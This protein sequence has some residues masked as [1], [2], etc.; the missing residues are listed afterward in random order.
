MED[1]ARSRNGS[2]TP[3]PP[4][5]S[6][7]RCCG[8]ATDKVD[9]DVEAE[10]ER[11]VPP[12]R[13]GRGRP[14]AGRPDRLAARR[15]RGSCPQ[16]PRPG[17]T[18]PP[19]DAT[20][21]RGRRAG[22][23]RARRLGAG[24]TSSARAGRLFASP[25][26][27]R[28]ARERGVDIAT[29]RGTGPER[30]RSSPTTSSRRRRARPHAAGRRQRRLAARAPAAAAA[31]RRSRRRR[32]ERPRRPD[33]AGRTSRPPPPRCCPPPTPP[34]QRPRRSSRSPGCAASSRR[35]CTPACQEMAQLTL[36]TDV[37]DGRRGRAAGPAQGAVGP[38]GIPVPTVTDLVVRAAALAL[39]EHPRLNA[40]VQDNA[41][42][43]QPDINVGLAVALDDGLIVPVV[44]DADRTAVVDDRGR[45]PA[46][47]AA[48]AGRQG[49]AARSRRRRRSPSARSAASASTSSRR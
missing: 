41:I 11:R 15:G 27:R 31:G 1:R 32:R 4:S 37:H 49:L 25:N 26:A 19:H 24:T 46:T 42:H 3:A 12:G 44:K 36:G 7:T 5:R 30:P 8:S 20:A 34:A 17:P 21:P 38:A 22:R 48:R 9:V 39:R 45:G 47:R 23:R 28:V 16:A 33:H 40:T 43:V 13:R 29:L 35:G 18:G 6:A 14:A 10:G 2:S